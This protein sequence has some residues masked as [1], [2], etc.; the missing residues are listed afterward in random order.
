MSHSLEDFYAHAV[1]PD[2]NPELWGALFN[3]NPYKI[4]GE[5]LNEKGQLQL[6]T[7]HPSSYSITGGGE[8]PI[9]H[10]P[11]TEME[12]IARFETAR[13]FDIDRY[14]VILPDFL[15]RCKCQL[16]DKK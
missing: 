4:S 11:G 8:H 7:V 15:K 12:Q 5:I 3:G 14:A 1:G 6:I 16:C 2:G 10:E 13:R 9:A